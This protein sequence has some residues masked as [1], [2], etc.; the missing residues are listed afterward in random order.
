M[1]TKGQCDPAPD[2]YNVQQMS[3]GNGQVFIEIGYGWD[4]VSVWPACA[5]PLVGARVSNTS[6]TTTWY[7]HLQGRK[8]QP[9]TVA[10]APNSARTYSAS[11]LSSVG[12][13]T[14]E[15]LSD[16]TLSLVP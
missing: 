3:K 13:T 10:I 1:A 8:G 5:G 16:L 2:P 6:A 4:G 14:L 9:V 7:A 12:L 15:D 11:Q